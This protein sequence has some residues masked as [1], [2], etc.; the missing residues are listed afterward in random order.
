MVSSDLY[1]PIQ[2]YQKGFLAVGEGHN[3]YWEVSGN[4]DGP[5]VVFLHGGPGAG[6][7]PLFRRFFDP[8][9]WRI[10]LFDQRGCGQSTPAAS[11]QANTTWDLVSDMEHLRRHLGIAQWLLFGG[12]WGSTLALAYG[13]THPQR[14]LGFILRGVFLFR[15]GEVH[16]FLYGMGQ[17]FPE[18]WQR[19]SGFLPPAERDDLLNAYS[20]RLTHPDPAIHLPAAQ[21]W[22]EYEDGCARLLPH[23]AAGGSRPDPAVA[24]AIARIECHFMVHRGFLLENQLLHNVTQIQHLPC[25][26]VQ[27][28]YD[29]ICPPVSALDLAQ[30]WPDSKLIMI[31]D[32]GHSALERGICQALVHAVDCVHSHILP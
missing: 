24:L 29:V 21:A 26:I 27:G 14:V 7:Q 6:T 28:R 4:A 12:S 17:F 1:P 20:R 30:K 3:L 2:P 25:T 31:P 11:L 10:V 13:E 16:W 19:F 23:G 15:P 18:I 9:K 32:A 22:Y 5:A 8:A